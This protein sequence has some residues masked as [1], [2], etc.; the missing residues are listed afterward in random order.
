MIKLR[1]AG[2]KH[3]AETNDNS[4]IIVSKRAVF[5]KNKKTSDEENLVWVLTGNIAVRE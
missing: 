5:Q 4:G 2:I 1:V 3:I